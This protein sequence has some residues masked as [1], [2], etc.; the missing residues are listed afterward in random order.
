[1]EA[2][3]E[4]TRHAKTGR[5]SGRKCSRVGVAVGGGGAARA[6]DRLVRKRFEFISRKES[7]GSISTNPGARNCRDDPT[8]G[9]VVVGLEARHQRHTL[10]L[11]ELRQVPLVRTRASECV[12]IQ[13]TAGRESG[14]P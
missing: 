13:R 4:S 12:P 10:A 6:N 8:L 11:Y 9:F 14:G 2:F 7:A 1:M 5:S 3:H